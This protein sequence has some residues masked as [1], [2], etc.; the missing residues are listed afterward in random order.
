VRTPVKLVVS[1]QVSADLQPNVVFR[2]L[3][4]IDPCV[5]RSFQALALSEV[6]NTTKIHSFTRGEKLTGGAIEQEITHQPGFKWTIR[7]L[8]QFAHLLLKTINAWE[9]FKAGEIRY[10][11]LPD[12]EAP[13]QTSW[14]SYLA[15]IDKDVTELRDLRSSLMHQTELFE[16]M[17][18]SVRLCF[19]F[20]STSLTNC[21][22]SLML[23]ISR[24]P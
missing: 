7:I 8:R 18:N 23:H 15:A 10:F 24:Q 12:T 4:D 9:T 19:P 13:A 2:L 1:V 14:G 5:S 3:Q 22:L 21:R 11:N 17:T 6:A 16:N 20:R